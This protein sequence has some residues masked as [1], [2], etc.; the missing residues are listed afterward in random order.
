[1]NGLDECVWGSLPNQ[2]LF[3]E[4]WPLF[5]LSRKRASASPTGHNPGERVPSRRVARMGG[6]CE[7]RSRIRPPGSPQ[8]L[9]WKSWR[10]RETSSEAFA[11]S[12]QLLRC[13]CLPN[14]HSNMTR[15]PT[16]PLASHAR[17]TRSRRSIEY[18]AIATSHGRITMAGICTSRK[19]SSKKCRPSK[20]KS[21]RAA[22]S[23]GNDQFARTKT[24][25]P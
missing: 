5:R 25:M 13:K 6:R 15:C 16:F 7:S 10:S 11:F 9:M 18:G 19:R 4:V 17:T 23:S 20:T 14:S 21:I 12:G 8:R 24:K 22:F 2:L 3:A 1:M